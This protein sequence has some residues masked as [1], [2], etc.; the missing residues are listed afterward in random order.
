MKARRGRAR[1]YRG[2]SRRQ[3]DRTEEPALGFRKDCEVG[4]FFYSFA[5]NY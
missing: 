2:R 3:I 4:S 5:N 1:S